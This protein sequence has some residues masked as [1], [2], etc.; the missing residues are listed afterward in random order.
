MN[1]IHEANQ[2]ERKRSDSAS[3]SGEE[4]TIYHP[5][6]GE[7]LD[8]DSI[9]YRA[10]YQFLN[11]ETSAQTRPCL[12]NLQQPP[13]LGEGQRRPVADH[14]PEDLYQGLDGNPPPD[15]NHPV[16]GIALNGAYNSRANTLIQEHNY[17]PH[18]EYKEGVYLRHP[19]PPLADNQ[20]RPDH[21]YHQA[22]PTRYEQ[23][24]PQHFCN[25]YLHQ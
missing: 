21:H 9:Q 4:P 6:T 11:E 25:S 23:V 14:P 20:P 12:N 2:P 16:Q 19:R 22:S 3:T 13:H 15:T 10:M 24:V 5:I 18:G 7:V 8:L 1:Q 17:M